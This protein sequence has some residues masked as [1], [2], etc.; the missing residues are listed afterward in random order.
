[1][2]YSTINKL[3]NE[4]SQILN[5][6]NLLILYYK[7]SHIVISVIIISKRHDCLLNLSNCDIILTCKQL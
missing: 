1:M 6:A 3:E 7:V 4:G 5:I 2:G